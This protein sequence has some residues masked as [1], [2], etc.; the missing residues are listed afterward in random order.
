MPT[1]CHA[2]PFFIVFG[3]STMG[4]SRKFVLLGGFPVCL[5]C[6][7]M[8]LGGFPVSLVHRVS[9]VEGSPTRCYVH[10]KDQSPI[11]RNSRSAMYCDRSRID[12]RAAGFPIS[13]ANER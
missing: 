1:A 13:A 5:C 9:P 7:F 8:P 3:G 12:E 6:K 10:E 4:L 11:D 2:I